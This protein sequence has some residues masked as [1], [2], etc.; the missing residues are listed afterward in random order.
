MLIPIQVDF[1]ALKRFDVG[2][3]FDGLSGHRR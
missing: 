3:F 1:I 2:K